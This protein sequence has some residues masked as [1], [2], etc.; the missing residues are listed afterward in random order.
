MTPL[1]QTISK[2]SDVSYHLYADDVQF[3]CSF[4]QTELYKL[5]NLTAIKNC[6]NNNL[7][8]LN[9]AKTETLIFAPETAYPLIKEH[10][11]QIWTNSRLY[12]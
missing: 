10:L 1:G 2:F 11:G 8:Q 9:S 4:K 12:Q 6:L 3:Y 5:H 7:L